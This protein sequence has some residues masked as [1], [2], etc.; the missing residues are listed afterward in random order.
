MQAASLGHQGSLG[1]PSSAFPVSSLGQLWTQV[2][3][4]TPPLGPQGGHLKDT[5][6][7]RKAD[8]GPADLGSQS[9]PTAHCPNLLGLEQKPGTPEASSV[10]CTVK[11][12]TG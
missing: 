12:S 2:P 10:L 3:R 8:S 1:T 4:D 7:E 5:V 9:S 6:A 11:L